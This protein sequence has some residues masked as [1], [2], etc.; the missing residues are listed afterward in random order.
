MVLLLILLAVLLG[1]VPVFAS[2]A[3]VQ[4]K[5]GE[6]AISLTSYTGSTW[7]QF[8]Q[9]N[10]YVANVPAGTT[11]V[12]ICL[13]YEGSLNRYDDDYDT[14]ATE[15]KANQWST[16]T[17]SNYP[18]SN[19]AFPNITDGTNYYIIACQD[20]DYL[21]TDIILVH[22][23]GGA[24]PK[25]PLTDAQKKPLTDLLATVADGN[26]KYVQSGD[27]YNGKEY[28]PNGF[29]ATFTEKDGPRAKAQNI[30][31]TATEESQIAAAVKEL[32]DAISNL[33]PADRLNTTP[34]Y[35]AIQRV[36]GLGYNDLSLK[37]YT[38]TSAALFKAGRDDAQ[39]YLE[40]VY[41]R[42]PESCPGLR[43][44][45]QRRLQAAFFSFHTASLPAQGAG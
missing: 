11:T 34:L 19:E 1:A 7:A 33:I 28:N 17:L 44:S 13:N 4:I 38:E 20:K 31:D 35:E 41:K 22:V 29:W 45:A 40:D 3:N 37:E 36:S 15:I 16:Q 5:V 2:D 25:P 23:G 27:C 21:W 6:S 39:K 9:K 24:E 18:F 26:D 12:D 14:W 30:L 8:Q 32:N 43:D 10:V 42:Q